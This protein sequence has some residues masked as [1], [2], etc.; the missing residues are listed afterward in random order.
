MKSGCW[1]LSWWNYQSTDVRL[2]SSAHE[3]KRREKQGEGWGQATAKDLSRRAQHRSIPFA[4]E[5]KR[6]GKEGER[7]KLTPRDYPS[8]CLRPPLA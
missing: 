3:G 8:G 5:K 1:G 2:R 7:R 4:P 6:R